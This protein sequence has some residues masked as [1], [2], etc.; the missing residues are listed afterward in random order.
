VPV[1]PQVVFWLGAALPIYA[2]FGYPVVLALLRMVIHRG[3]KKG[4]FEPTVS[5]VI[6]AYKEEA[7]IAAKIRQ[8]LALDYPPEKLE[9]LVACD[10]SP[11]GTVRV[12]TEAAKGSRVRIL[13][14]PVNRG[15]IAT[16][17]EA[18]REAKSDILLFTD[19]SSTLFPDAVR[20]LMMSMAD[21]TVGSVG[22]K[23]TIVNAGDVDI[24]KSEDLYWKYET[25]LKTYEA[26]LSSTLGAHG[27]LHAIRRS[28]Y[29]FP[30]PGMI[31]DDYLIPLSVLSKGY[32]S[33][34]E[35]KAICYE[36]AAEMT[37]FGRRIR[38][39]TGNFQQL[40]EIRNL[41]NPLQPL[42]LMF[43]LSRKVIRLAV[44]FGMIAAFIANLFLLDSPLYMALFIGQLV[45][46]ALAIAGAIIKLQPKL[47][48]LPYY[49]SMI[50]TAVFFGLYHALT[51]RRH[52]AW[53]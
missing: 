22:G 49:F 51:D 32:R 47:L 34:Y 10:G 2:Y 41:L 43:F 23:Y 15:K 14:Y 16:L 19:A 5:M 50:N 31:N 52:M 53:K 6:P 11:D 3:V 9:I 35:P 38:I 44:P 27:Q 28:L 8:S 46:Y 4:P 26:E 45:F 37:G 48:M 29:P 12:A 20:L 36:Q 42:P 30:K 21:P 25:R 18:V 17:N 1:I 39:M 24:G 7:V 13:D 33:V 40:P